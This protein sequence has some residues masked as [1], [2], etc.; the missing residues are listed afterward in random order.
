MDSKIMAAIIAATATLLSPL[1]VLFVQEKRQYLPISGMK[2]SRLLAW[3]GDWNGNFI[4]D[5]GPNNDTINVKLELISF[6]VKNRK[7]SGIAKY[8]WEN[9][10]VTLSLEGKFIAN[11]TVE[12]KYEDSDDRIVRH[13]TIMLKM[14][15]DAK[16]IQGAFLGFGAE[17]ETIVTGSIKLKRS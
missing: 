1:L 4:Q 14:S 11:D 6:V 10:P 7:I 5:R 13:G 15:S 12:L 2:K 17:S 9:C 3:I 16:E 8:N